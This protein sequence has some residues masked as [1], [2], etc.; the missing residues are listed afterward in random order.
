MKQ[1]TPKLPY[2]YKLL[3]EVEVEGDGVHAHGDGAFATYKRLAAAL[4]EDPRVIHVA[5]WP[6]V[7]YVGKQED[8][9]GFNPL[10]GA[11]RGIGRCAC[12]AGP[13]TNPA[14]PVHP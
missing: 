1:S 4:G 3:L 11:A 14:C 2:R 6:E 9:P 5:R 7:S 8:M 12:L 13:G 10:G